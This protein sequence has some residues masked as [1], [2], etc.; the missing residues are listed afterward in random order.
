MVALSKSD[1]KTQSCPPPPC[2]IGDIDLFYTLGGAF[3][4]IPLSALPSAA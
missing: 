1:R 4:P 2:P 3:H